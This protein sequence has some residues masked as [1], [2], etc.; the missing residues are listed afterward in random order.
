M[1]EC[2]KKIIITTIIITIIVAII[3]ITKFG[4]IT[5]DFPIEKINWNTVGIIVPTIA[6]IV[7]II[8]ESK[9]RKK[10]IEIQIKSND[11]AEFKKFIISSLNTYENIIVRLSNHQ[12]NINYSSPHIINYDDVKNMNAIAQECITFVRSFNNNIDIY[13]GY[14][15]K[16][17]PH[18]DKFITELNHMNELL[19]ERVTEFSNI[20]NKLLELNEESIHVY[21]L[22][23][24][25]E[26]KEGLEKLAIKVNKLLE[27]KG[28]KISKIIE[29]YCKRS[30]NIYGLALKMIE[31]RN[32]LL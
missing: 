19:L 20:G 30:A 27:E 8:N 7:T 17:R 13:Y 29:L 1:N 21:Y 2:K 11:I 5:F 24:G 3:L 16:D 9:R 22:P 14:V 18:F 28:E 10:E 23:D 25:K 32:R 6:L 26:K 4:W 15:K 12:M 31:E